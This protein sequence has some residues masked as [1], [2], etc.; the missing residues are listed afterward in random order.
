MST[1]GGLLHGFSTLADPMNLLYVVIGVVLGTVVGVLPG[2]GPTA[3]IAIILPVTYSLPPSS[4]LIML[5][6]IYYGAMYGGSTTSI[7]LNIP[8]EAASVVTAIDG[9]QMARQGRAGAALGLA[10]IGSFVAGTVALIGLSFLAPP[11]AS[12]AL[13]FG[14]PEYTA[15]TL[16]GLLLVTA[17]SGQSLLKGIISALFGLLIAT[18][19]LD[20]VTG[21]PR[22][23][24]GIN[25]ML[26]GVDF[27]VIAMGVFGVT[28]IVS[29]LE[30]EGQVEILTTKITNI[31]P[32]LKDWAEAKWA[33]LRGSL[34][35]FAVG[36]LPGGGAVIS[37]LASYAIEKKL[38]K[39]PEQFGKGA[40][41]GVAGPESANNAAAGSSFIPL[42][43]M[44][45]PANSVM[46]MMFAA[47]MI[48]GI[49]PGPFMIRD[50]AEVFWGLIASMYIGN[51]FLLI[52]NLPM[53]GLFVQLLKVP[54]AILGPLALMVTLVGAFSIN[55]SLFDL[56][57]ISVFGVV[58]YFMRRFGYDAGPLVLAFVLGPLIE[59]SFKQSLLMSNGSL[60]IFID[61][62]IAATLLATFAVLVIWQVV[63]A[64]RK[65][66]G[67]ERKAS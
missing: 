17:L 16:L 41:A 24:F 26:S 35:G 2:L 50:H 52:L 29:S 55:N 38:S 9:Y 63:G 13:R 45:I 36:V 47:L 20:V 46:A 59:K 58:G 4:A 14:P 23:T 48:H 62:P 42:L 25:E 37:S 49:T 44:G 21:V 61:S 39:H 27:A 31:W 18:V 5:A 60:K 51:V 12:F 30:E 54:Y 1:I 3:T 10:A 28:E 34:L 33:V 11:I 56:L 22:F 32:T 19:G 40:I 57:A 7:L 67:A 65:L 53:V 43:T 8:G 64:M 66:W 15:L 6:G